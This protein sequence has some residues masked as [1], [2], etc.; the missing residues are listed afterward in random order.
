[1]KTLFNTLLVLFL[2]FAPK[3]FA[4]QKHEI[5]LEQGNQFN[6]EGDYGK[7]LKKYDE[8]IKINPQFAFAY[9]QRSQIYYKFNDNKKAIADCVK[10]LQLDPKIFEAYFNLAIARFYD[11]DYDRAIIDFSTALAL[12]PKDKEAFFWRGMAYLKMN[13]KKSACKDWKKA[14]VLGYLSATDLIDQHCENEAGAQ[15]RD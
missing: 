8:A 6:A 9:H 10:A 1:M 14:R 2:C 13:D 3:I 11:K 15:G 7:A 12:N 4:Q 5:L